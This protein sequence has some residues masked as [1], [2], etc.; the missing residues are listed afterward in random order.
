MR[1]VIDLSAHVSHA[2]ACRCFGVARS[3]FYRR[4]RPEPTKSATD[5][6]ARSVRR[7]LSV[8]ER[9]AAAFDAHPE[10]FVRG[11]PRPPAH[12]TAAWINPPVVPFFDELFGSQDRAVTSIDPTITVVSAVSN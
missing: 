10:R 7:R 4:R 1:A 6:A 2:A 12:P 8:E 9:A 5:G 11:M 3:C